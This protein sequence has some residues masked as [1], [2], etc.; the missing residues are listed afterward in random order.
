MC[1]FRNGFSN[2][3]KMLILLFMDDFRYFLFGDER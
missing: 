1:I 3:C 2:R